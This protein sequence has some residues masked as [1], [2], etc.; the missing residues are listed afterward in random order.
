[1]K[2][3]LYV[4]FEKTEKEVVAYCDEVNAVASGATKAEAETNLRKAIEALI[5]EYDHEIKAQLKKKVL[6]FLEVA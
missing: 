3:P 6:T 4:T 5:K 1:M 2:Y